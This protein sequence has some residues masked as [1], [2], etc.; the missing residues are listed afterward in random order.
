MRCPACLT[1]VTEEARFC[2]WCGCSFDATSHDL[3]L[4]SEETLSDMARVVFYIVSLLIPIAGLLIGASYYT[5]PSQELKAVGKSCLALGCVNLVLTIWCWA[6]PY[7]RNWIVG[8]NILA[9]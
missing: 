1:T 3:A 5:R 7:I 2:P 6:L 9:I 4:Q 8:A